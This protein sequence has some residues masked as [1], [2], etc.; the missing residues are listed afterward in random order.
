MNL[1]LRASK[2][3]YYLT[4]LNYFVT[5]VFSISCIK[6]KIYFFQKKSLNFL[7]LLLLFTNFLCLMTL[8]WPKTGNSLLKEINPQWDCIV[9]KKCA[10]LKIS[11]EQKKRLKKFFDGK[12]ISKS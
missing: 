6:M 5:M 3:N 1:N 4:S 2:E 9:S 10:F 12:R 7:R 11:W 8:K